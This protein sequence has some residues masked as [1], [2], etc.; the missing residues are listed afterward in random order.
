[1]SRR[2]TGRGLLLL[3]PLLMLLVALAVL[4]RDSEDGLRPLL[5]LRAQVRDARARVVLLEARAA[6]LQRD[7]DAMRSDEL[8]VEAAARSLLGMVRPG[9]IV[10]RLDAPEAP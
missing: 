7:A 5:G 10:V 9:E 4:W 3:P 6:E 1:M 8:A 2:S